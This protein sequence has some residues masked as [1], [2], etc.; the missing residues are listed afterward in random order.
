M[1]TNTEIDT[2]NLHKH[3]LE[4]NKLIKYSCRLGHTK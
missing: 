1:S 2:S 4:L 3:L